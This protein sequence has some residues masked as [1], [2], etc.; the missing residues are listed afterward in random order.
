MWASLWLKMGVANSNYICMDIEKHM[1]INNVYIHVS[2]DICKNPL[3]VS[4]IISIY[5][6]RVHH[7]S[8]KLARF[9]P[10]K[11]T[12]GADVEIKELKR[13]LV[14]VDLDF[15]QFCE[16][17]MLPFLPTWMKQN[18]STNLC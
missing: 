9:H 11:L 18:P 17:F 6:S 1:H 2:C 5:N 4:T 3:Q 12:T 10:M 8:R 7:S 13:S 16:G 14:K 15:F